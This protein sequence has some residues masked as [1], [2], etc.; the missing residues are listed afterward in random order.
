MSDS[1]TEQPTVEASETKEPTSTRTPPDRKTVP[2]LS[3]LKVTR[4][5]GLI[6][7]ETR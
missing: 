6:T 4:W 7:L 5:G 2:S 1:K 3:D